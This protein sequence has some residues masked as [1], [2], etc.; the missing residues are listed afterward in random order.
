VRIF[1]GHDLA[2]M[3]L[4]DALCSS[5]HTEENAWGADEVSITSIPLYWRIPL[6]WFVL[7]K[8]SPHLEERVVLN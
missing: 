5:D 7:W 3:T 4:N 2:Y 8:V 1:D 6:T